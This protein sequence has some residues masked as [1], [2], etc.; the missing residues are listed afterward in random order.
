MLDANVKIAVTAVKVDW[1]GID[2]LAELR[3]NRKKV[4]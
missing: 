4:D 3:R 1:Q 2:H